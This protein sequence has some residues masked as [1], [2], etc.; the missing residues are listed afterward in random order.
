MKI[1]LATVSKVTV[2]MAMV[3]SNVLE[4]NYYL[5]DLETLKALS[6]TISVGLG[7]SKSLSNLP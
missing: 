4:I 3:N 7:V 2:S 6:S 1:T 5:C